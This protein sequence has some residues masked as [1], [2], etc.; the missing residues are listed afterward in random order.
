[1]Y[2]LTFK[3]TDLVGEVTSNTIFGLICR[4]YK[5]LHGE[6]TLE[7]FLEMLKNKEEIL[8]LSN[9]LHCNTTE[10][11]DFELDSKSGVC[12]DRD[13]LGNNILFNLDVSNISEFDILVETS[14]TLS[15]LTQLTNIMKVFGLGKRKSIGYGEIRSIEIK[16]ESLSNKGTKLRNLSN[17][18]PCDKTPTTGDI[19]LTGRQGITVNGEEQSTYL[20][21]QA[22]SLFD[23]E[24]VDTNILG[25]I[26][27]DEK[28][29]T[30]INGMS[31]VIRE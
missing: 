11:I 12:I 7:L 19:H 24:D 22:N 28:T 1:M 14:M 31:I 16:E 5:T 2:R 21:I 18:F 8:V 9:P 30:Y 3:V 4:A 25:Q 15:E 10:I 23:G 20:I 29:K 17:I 27:Y 26:I 13:G 6:D